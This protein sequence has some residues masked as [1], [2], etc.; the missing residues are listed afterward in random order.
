[1]DVVVR[2]AIKKMAY[3][4]SDCMKFFPIYNE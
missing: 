1:M 2:V 4:I 3:I